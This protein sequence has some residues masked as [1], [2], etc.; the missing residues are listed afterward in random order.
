MHLVS[1]F[2]GWSAYRG[3]IH[4]RQ[5]WVSRQTTQLL[6][7]GISDGPGLIWDEWVPWIELLL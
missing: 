5:D 3:H 6:L 2:S 1:S 4:A 7:Q